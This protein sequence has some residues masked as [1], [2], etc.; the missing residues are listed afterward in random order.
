MQYLETEKPDIL[1]I[2]ETKCKENEIP[3]N[4]KRSDYHM[5]WSSA[6]QAG[7]AGTGIYTKQ[8]PLNVTY[9]LGK[10]HHVTA[11]VYKNRQKPLIQSMLHYFMV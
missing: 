5:Y 9:G 11:V 10:Y 6:E 8:K 3:A 1:C 7:Y 4:A 2:Q